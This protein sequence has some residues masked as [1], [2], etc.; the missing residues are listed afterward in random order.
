MILR[1]Y[2]KYPDGPENEGRF[3]GEGEDESGLGLVSKSNIVQ[4]LGHLD[5]LVGPEQVLCFFT[6]WLQNENT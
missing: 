3:G 2:S 1:I 6:N 4:F 5:L